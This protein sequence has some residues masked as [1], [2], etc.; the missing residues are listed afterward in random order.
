MRSPLPLDR[1]FDRPLA[2]RRPRRAGAARVARAAAVLA[3]LATLL[4]PLGCGR[5]E[6]PATD[7]GHAADSAEA[8]GSATGS[9]AKPDAPAAAL[10]PSGR[11]YGE[12]RAACADRDPLRQAFWGEL[13]VHSALSMDAWLWDVRTT[14]DDVY[15]F[16]KGESILLPPLDAEGRGTRPV[17]LKRPLDF[18]ALTDHAD[19]QGEVVLC[20]RADSPVYDSEICR[21][22]R[23]ENQTEAPTPAT[24]GQRMAGLSNALAAEASH[25]GRSSALCGADAELCRTAMKTVWQEQQAAAER[26][27]DRS[28]ACRFTT[29][30]AYEYTATPALAKVHHNVIF[31]N[32]RVPEAP[33][34]WID[35][36][37]VYDLWSR[38]RAECQEAGTGCDVLTIPHNSNLSNG[39]MFAVTGRDLPLE[40]Q[41]AR[42]MLR[43]DLERLVEIS[44]IKG[45]SECRNDAWNVIG[46]TDEL[47]G[48]EQWRG[49]KFEDCR[50]STGHGALFDQGCVA[51]T[52]FVRYALLEGLREERRLGV[53]PYK[54]GVIAAT[55]SH[56]GTPGDVEE[57]SYDGWAG[58]SDA[59]PASRLA[60]PAQKVA[61]TYPA[62]SNPGGIAGVWA[63]ENSRDA[64][65]DAMKRRETFG[66]SGP[67]MTARFFGGWGLPA[68]LCAKP[69]LVE[70]GYAAGVPMG[71]DLPARP[72]AAKAPAFVVSALRDAG[73][74]E[75]PGGQLQRVQIVKGWV[76]AEE[77]FHQVVHDVAGGPNDAGVD[78][79]TCAPRGEGH[80]SLCAVWTDPDFDPAQDAVYYV[81][82]LENPSCRWTALQCLALPE[83]ERPGACADPAIPKTIQERLWTSPIWYEAP[84][85]AATA[86]TATGAG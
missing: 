51:R 53:N 3:L 84:A 14:P 31:R 60:V 2:T 21:N 24:F 70:R 15:R 5:D 18:V 67:R 35:V 79:A 46:A 38:L 17:Q 57:W 9:A 86:A 10:A 73:T 27:Y 16:G 12:A 39:N 7:G 65:F 56:N 64:I 20:T 82:V 37:D 47:C 44:Q 41:R 71:G 85:G 42:A 29:F 77:R 32:E 26:H 30:N 68:D 83:A 49:P 40:Q 11:P 61:L 34:P 63:E 58:L 50:E 13:H 75:H 69:D 19:F 66:T 76:D 8:D 54:L 6:A 4:G 48:Y 81:R 74:P 80:E 23:G 55:D 59:T 22:Y 72:D 1:P 78:P 25:V 36:P 52:D 45:D 33:I 62:M 28:A 43:V